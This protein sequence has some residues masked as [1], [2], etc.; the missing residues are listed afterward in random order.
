MLATISVDVVQLE[1]LN[2][3]G[4]ATGTL[5]ARLPAAVLRKDFEAEFGVVFSCS[6]RGD[7]NH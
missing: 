3:G 7:G 1:E 6:F 4:F 2:E 5:A